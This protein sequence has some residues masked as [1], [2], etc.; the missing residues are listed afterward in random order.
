MIAYRITPGVNFW[1]ISDDGFEQLYFREVCPFSKLKELAWTA[2]HLY[3]WQTPISVTQSHILTRSKQVEMRLLIYCALYRRCL[4]AERAIWLKSEV[5][6]KLAMELVKTWRT[7]E[8]WE[9]LHKAR[10][11]VE[12]W[13]SPR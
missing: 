7:K 13:T 1:I 3:A 12:L 6:E 4:C 9:V 8:Y 2:W 10:E 11:A 5:A